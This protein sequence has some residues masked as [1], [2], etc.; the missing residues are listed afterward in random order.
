MP[1]WIG[2]KKSKAGCSNCKARKVKCDEVHP[3]CGACTRHDIPCTWGPASNSGLR[4]RHSP[5]SN[6]EARRTPQSNVSSTPAGDASP[7]NQDPD[8]GLAETT[9]RRLLELRLMSHYASNVHEFLPAAHGIAHI[10]QQSIPVLALKHPFLLYALLAVSALHIKTTRSI[11]D[12]AD[13]QEHRLTS[14]SPAEMDQMTNAQTFYFN[15]ALQK[16]REAVQSLNSDNA[17][18]ACI[19]TILISNQSFQLSETGSGSSSAVPPLRWLRLAH[20]TP[21]IINAAKD[22]LP[23]G[24]VTMNVIDNSRWEES[25]EDRDNDE[26]RNLLP[27]LLRDAAETEPEYGPE[28]QAA[29]GLALNYIGGNLRRIRSGA[30]HQDMARR[31]SSFP[32]I[33]PVRFFELAEEGRP[34]ALIVLAYLFCM[35]KIAEDEWY[36]HGVASRQVHGTMAL[37]DSRWHEFMEWPLDYLRGKAT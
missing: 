13:S 27:D 3:T 11:K 29:Y 12:E 20:S 4:S 14:I 17:D 21:V 37:L 28:T 25:H 31:F 19:A 1:P 24:S 8:L 16:Q 36:F 30:S 35:M 32:P 18:A 34:R 22:M 7:P 5:Y 10:F 33:M 15:L 23:A 6:E 9:E 26:N 2:H